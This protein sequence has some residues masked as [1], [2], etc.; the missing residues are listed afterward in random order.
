M[1]GWRGQLGLKG[2]KGGGEARL[3]VYLAG[4]APTASA[5]ADRCGRGLRVEASVRSFI[6][7]RTAENGHLQL[8]GRG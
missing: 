2:P 6:F 3:S 8:S 7:W 5:S 1:T 4:Y